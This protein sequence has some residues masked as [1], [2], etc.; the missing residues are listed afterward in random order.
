MGFSFNFFGEQQHRTFNYKPRYYDPEKEERRRLFGQ[1]DGLD[2]N[3]NPIKEDDSYTPG[4]Y[5]SGSFR[6]GNYQQLKT[7]GMGK[8]RLYIGIIG[9]ILFFIVLYYLAQFYA[10]ILK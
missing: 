7:P 3:G 10:M 1:V 5:I 6:E 2:A 4:K 9:M 8:I